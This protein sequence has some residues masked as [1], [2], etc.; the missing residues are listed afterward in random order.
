MAL[1]RV[2]QQGRGEVTPRLSAQNLTLVIFLL[3]HEGCTQK[4]RSSIPA[5]SEK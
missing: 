2:T 1:A 4:T 5:Q 3:R